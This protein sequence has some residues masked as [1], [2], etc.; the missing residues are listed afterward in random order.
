MV[1]KKESDPTE[2]AQYRTVYYFHNPSDTAIQVE[3]QY[4]LH[5]ESAWRKEADGWPI[6]VDHQARV[7]A[8]NA[9]QALYTVMLPEPYDGKYYRPVPVK[10]Y[11]VS[12]APT[13]AA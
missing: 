2:E 7:M 4:M 12:N 3:F 6:A 1:P 8:P 5:M 11:L 9:V 10:A 13:I